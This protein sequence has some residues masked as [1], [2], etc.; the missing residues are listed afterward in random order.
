[1]LLR[2]VHAASARQ[3]HDVQGLAVLLGVGVGI[4]DLGILQD[5][6][7]LDALVDFHQV[8]ID[9][10]TA[11]DVQVTYLAVAHLSVGQTHILAASLERAVRI[12]RTQEVKIRSR[13]T[14][15]CIAVTFG[16]LA[17]TVQNHQ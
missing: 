3:A 16:T 9:N 17:P 13:G 2:T 4:D 1:M 11:A 15:N 7:V 8:L 14:I 6:A 12:G 10:T 5:R